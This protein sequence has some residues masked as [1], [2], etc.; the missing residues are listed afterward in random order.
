MN[1]V[2]IVEQV[3]D[4]DDGDCLISCEKYDEKKLADVG[5]KHCSPSK[6]GESIGLYATKSLVAFDIVSVEFPRVVMVPFA[7]TGLLGALVMV[8]DTTF[9]M[10]SRKE[11]NTVAGFDTLYPRKKEDI[12]IKDWDYIKNTYGKFH[13]TEEKQEE[14]CLFY[15]KYNRNVFSHG[16][17]IELYPLNSFFNHSCDPNCIMAKRN[18][19]QVIMAARPIEKGSELTISYIED[20]DDTE[21]L[22]ALLGMP[23]RCKKCVP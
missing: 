5:Y 10:L 14:F 11:M 22:N 19:A 23:C 4:K 9:A 12:N 17:R 20:I 15:F 18:G 6:N 16:G 7:G 21:Y 3:G 1:K 2:I 13:E 8:A